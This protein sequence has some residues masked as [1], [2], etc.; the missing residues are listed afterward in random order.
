MP[1]G[2]QERNSADEEFREKRKKDRLATGYVMPTLPTHA[3]VG[4]G[5]AEVFESATGQSP[6]PLFWG[7][8]AGLSMLPDLDVLAFSLGIPYEHPFGHRGFFHS[9]SCALAISLLVALLTLGQFG[10]AWWAMW[11]YFF[12]VMAS[13]GV[14]DAFTN[15]GMGIALLAPFS[16]KRYFFPWQPIQVSPL[17]RVFFSRWGLRVLVSEIVWVW[18][19]LAVLVG[20]CV[21]LA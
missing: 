21:F 7:L 6:S 1:V 9:L 15:G 16:H 18:A 4:L 11:I 3:L 8:S 19:P 10:A 14:L 20:V 17:G 2:S 13:H 12:I 5:M